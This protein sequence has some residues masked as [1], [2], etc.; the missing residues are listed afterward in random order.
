MSTGKLEGRESAIDADD[1]AIAGLSSTNLGTSADDK[2][3]VAAPEASSSDQSDLEG[4]RQKNALE[5]HCVIAAAKSKTVFVNEPNQRT[6]TMSVDL[7][8]SSNDVTRA[9]SKGRKSRSVRRRKSTTAIEE[10]SAKSKA[11]KTRKTIEE[12]AL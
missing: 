7:S 6:G 3:Y 10:A 4:E 11:D 1:S 5:L 9:Q 8:E 2:G 12:Q